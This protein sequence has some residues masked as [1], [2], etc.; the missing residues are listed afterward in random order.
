MKNTIILTVHNKEKT[1]SRILEG[2]IKN[3]SRETSKLII[4]LDGCTDKTEKKIKKFFTNNKTFLILEII[5]TDD[6]WETKANNVGLKKV[7]TEFVTIVQ[8]DMLIL[9]KNWDK[10]LLKN[11]YKYKIFAVSG[12]SAHNFNFNNNNFQIVDLIGREYP[13]SSKNIFGKIVGKLFTIFK[14][15]WLYKYLNLTAIR[16]VVNRGPLMLE[17]SKLKKLNFFDE[18]FA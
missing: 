4:I 14:P 18:E 7:Q 17:I 9:Q 15:Y 11:F 8:D 1:V 2:L 12:R 3:T 10:K 5:C 6:I 16:L 13:F